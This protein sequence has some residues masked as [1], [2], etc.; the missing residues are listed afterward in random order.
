MLTLHLYPENTDSTI[1]ETSLNMYQTIWDT[2]QKR[3]IF[4]KNCFH[5]KS[6][7]CGI[8]KEENKISGFHSGGFEEYHL[9]GYDAV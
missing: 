5:S 9:L 4:R 1:S 7:E 3:V 6:A 2:F 8:G